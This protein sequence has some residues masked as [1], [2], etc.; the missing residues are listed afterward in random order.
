MNKDKLKALCHKLS[1]ES[2]L[3]FNMIQTHYF[4]ERI[5]EQI[6]SSCEC[7]NFIFKSGFLLSNVIGIR[8]RSTLDIDFV[9][10]Q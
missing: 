6:S 4:L 2:G 3:P 10:R 1:K 7:E 9:I 8:Q 5:L